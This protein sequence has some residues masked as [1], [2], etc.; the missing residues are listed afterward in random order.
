MDAEDYEEYIPLLYEVLA[1]QQHEVINA[2][3]YLSDL[4]VT[5]IMYLDWQSYSSVTQGCMAC[6]IFF[7]GMI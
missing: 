1:G 6:W 4:C 2:H 5:S 7:E 3:A